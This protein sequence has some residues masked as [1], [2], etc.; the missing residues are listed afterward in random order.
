MSNILYGFLDPNEKDLKILVEKLN[1]FEKRVF[2]L[3][4]GLVYQPSTGDE[5]DG[6]D[7]Q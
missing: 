1:Q 3:E 6:V 5:E 4:H 2:A 7:D